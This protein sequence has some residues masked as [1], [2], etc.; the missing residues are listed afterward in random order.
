MARHLKNIS[1]DEGFLHIFEAHPAD[2][3]SNCHRLFLISSLRCP[4]HG[5]PD[6]RSEPHSPN[7]LDTNLHF[8]P[9]VER[10]RQSDSPM[11]PCENILPD[12]AARRVFMGVWKEPVPPACSR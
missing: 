1:R 8:N 12:Y 3:L 6:N 10:S 5:R 4:I 7:P 9:P 2:K 11:K